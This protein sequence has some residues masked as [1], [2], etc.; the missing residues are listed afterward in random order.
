MSGPDR[1]SE[2]SAA[3]ATAAAGTIDDKGT[4]QRVIA[5]RKTGAAT[6]KAEWSEPAAV[7]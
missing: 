4:A 7:F 1:R 6:R 3:M 5:D 2:R